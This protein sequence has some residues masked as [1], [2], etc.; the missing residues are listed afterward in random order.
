MRHGNFINYGY[1]GTIIMVIVFV[2]AILIFSV[3]IINYLT[4]KD[5]PEQ[6]RII[7]LLE[8]RHTFNE[9]SQDDYFE[10][11]EILEDEESKDSSILILMERYA[12]G[13]I[14][15]RE[16]CRRRNEIKEN[17]SKSALNIL[18]E[19]YAKGDIEADEFQR[20]KKEL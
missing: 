16:F 8:Q 11:L 12:K 15:S 5:N 7:E 3:L 1:N 13:E 14:D 4:R 18:K 10:R 2:I 9:I 17:A 6:N 20:M 19:R